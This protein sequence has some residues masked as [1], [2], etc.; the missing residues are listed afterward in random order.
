VSEALTE[1]FD[2]L[3]V[4]MISGLSSSEVPLGEIS[5]ADVDL[6]I[7][8]IERRFAFAGTIENFAASSAQFSAIMG[9]PPSMPPNLNVTDLALAETFRETI[10]R[11]DWQR[12]ARRH[13]PAN[14]LYRY[15]A[16]RESLQTRLR[17]KVRRS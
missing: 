6:A 10:G 1:E 9:L 11:I 17:V 8:N 15:V 5:K 3:E 7:S 16:T 13:E 14:K 12:V 4:R 2:N